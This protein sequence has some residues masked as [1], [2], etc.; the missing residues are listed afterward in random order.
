MTGP[1]GRR[2]GLDV[3]LEDADGHTLAQSPPPLDPTKDQTVERL[4]TTLDAGTYY[5]RVVAMENGATDYY[6]RF[7]LTT[8]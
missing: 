4:K 2:H 7:G 3:W 5:I 6:L 8:P 1:E